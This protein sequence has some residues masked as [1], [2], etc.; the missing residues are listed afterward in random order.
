MSTERDLDVDLAS[1]ES[2]KPPT[3]SLSQLFQECLRRYSQLCLALGQDGC[4]VVKLEHI[5]L[6]KARGEFG[7][8]RLWGSQSKAALPAQA[9]GSLDDALRHD[10]TIADKVADMFRLLMDQL[11]LGMKE[12]VCSLFSLGLLQ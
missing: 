4:E 5:D 7:R 10:Q 6:E 2:L 8:L 12:P 1:R 9:R 3:Q 11:D